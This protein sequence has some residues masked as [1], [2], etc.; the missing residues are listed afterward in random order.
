MTMWT[1][2]GLIVL[3]PLA[4]AL[5]LLI[6]FMCVYGTAHLADAVER[7]SYRRNLRK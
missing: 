6:V 1:V 2:L 3:A 4:I 5:G 7:W